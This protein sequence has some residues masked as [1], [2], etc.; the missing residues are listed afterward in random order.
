MAA[1]IVATGEQLEA[2]YRRESNSYGLQDFS[3][4]IA[5]SASARVL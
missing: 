5:V 3:V 1:S 2:I 4:F